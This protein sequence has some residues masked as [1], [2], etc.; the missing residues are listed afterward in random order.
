MRFIASKLAGAFLIEPEPQ[1]D[2]RGFFARSWCSREFAE[3][4]LESR[5]VQCSISYNERRGTLRGLHYQQPPHEEVKLVRCT[6]GKVFDVI[7]DLRP[8]SPTYCAWQA[9]ELSADNHRSVYVPAGIA[10]GY[11][12]LLDRSE[13][14]YQMSEFYHAE[15]ARGLRWDDPTFSIA[16][17]LP[18]AVISPKDAFYGLLETTS[19]GRRAA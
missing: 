17:P 15:A 8:Q 2:Q 6:R 5:L 14:C 7:V 3:R 4:G 11:Q 13:V 18:V 19:H 9:Y 16:W 1:S 10:H 12:T